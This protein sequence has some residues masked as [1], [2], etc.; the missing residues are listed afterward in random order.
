MAE[1]QYILECEG[2]SKSFGGTKA[3][4]DVQ[5]HLKAGEVHALQ[6]SQH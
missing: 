6:E 2:I 4:K 3:L 1:G 5:L